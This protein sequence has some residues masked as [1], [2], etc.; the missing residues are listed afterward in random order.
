MVMTIARAGWFLLRKNV[1]SESIGLGPLGPRHSYRSGAT[2]DD[3]DGVLA[4]CQTGHLTHQLLGL[5][6]ARGG[7]VRRRASLAVNLDLDLSIP[8]FFR[9]VDRNTGAGER[10]RPGITGRGTGGEILVVVS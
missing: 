8:R 7:K 6:R 2:I 9:G 4:R 3:A 10:R 5:A 1:E